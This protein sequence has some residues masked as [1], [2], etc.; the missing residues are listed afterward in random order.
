MEKSSED[1]RTPKNPTSKFFI[2]RAASKEQIN[3]ATTKNTWLFANSIKSQIFKFLRR[4]SE[5]KVFVLFNLPE[6]KIFSGLAEFVVTN[7]GYQIRVVTHDDVTYNF[8][9]NLLLNLQVSPAQKPLHQFYDGEEIPINV[10][11]ALFQRL[12]NA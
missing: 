11:R 9:Q 2:V 7:S 6:L 1:W 12:V 4:N 3:E 5:S 8:M 10:A